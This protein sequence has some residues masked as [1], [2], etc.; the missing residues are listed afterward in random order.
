MIELDQLAD[1]ITALEQR[2]GA[3]GFW[4]SQEAVQPVVAEF[5]I[6]KGVVNP[7]K[8]LLKKLEDLEILHELAREA[9]SRDDLVEA[10]AESERVAADLERLELRTMLGGPHDM[11][12]CY[13]SVHAGA[14]GTE[15]CDWAEMLYRM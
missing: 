12:N 3:P 5:K 4:D 10:A 6:L 14:G 13:F 8:A 9:D 11:G 2:M 15:S 7:M 1:V